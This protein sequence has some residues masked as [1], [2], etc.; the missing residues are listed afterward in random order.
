[1]KNNYFSIVLI[2]Q[3][4]KEVAMSHVNYLLN[5]VGMT[6]YLDRYPNTLSKGEYQRISLLRSISNTPEIVI[7]DEPTANLDENNCKLLLNLIVKLNRSLDITFLIATH[8]KRFLS[9]S[10]SSYELLN[11]DLVK[12]E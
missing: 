12:N 10:N 9:I 4:T 8:D 7:A 2:N 3:K 6:D 11:G 5:L 1:M